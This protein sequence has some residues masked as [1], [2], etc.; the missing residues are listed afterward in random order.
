MTTLPDAVVTHPSHTVFDPTAPIV[1]AY[2]GEAVE[3]LTQARDAAVALLD[4]MRADKVALLALLEG[5]ETLINDALEANAKLRER[6]GE[7]E[8]LLAPNAVG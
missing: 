7:L 1:R 8:A 6:V 5:R 4:E 3:A 2:S